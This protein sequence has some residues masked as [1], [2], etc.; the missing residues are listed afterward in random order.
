[1][2]ALGNRNFPKADHMA[3][4]PLTSC[5]HG[6]SHLERQRFLPRKGAMKKAHVQ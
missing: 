2:R 5:R 1:M 6:L 4:S 3:A